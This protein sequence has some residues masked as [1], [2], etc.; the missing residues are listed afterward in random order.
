[1][2]TT[3]IEAS[4]IA[5]GAVPSTGFTSVQIFTAASTWTK[6]TDI[7]KVVVEVQGAGGAG[8]RHTTAGNCGGGTAG[9]YVMA[10][11]DVTDIDKATV[12]IGSGGVGTNTNGAGADGG[13]S[14]FAKHTGSGTFVTLSA[15][16]GNGGDGVYETGTQ[17]VGGTGPSGAL[18]ISSGNT[19]G[20]LGTE[21]FGGESKF[22]FAGTA[23]YN[24]YTQYPNASGYGAGGGGAYTITAG[25]GTGGLVIVWEYK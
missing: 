8:A 9:G 21:W 1:L 16:G 23:A 19:G 13:L 12:V 20:G 4:N 10:V 5:T 25:S 3:K 17:G 6:P 7:T 22:G 18:I 11:L 14:S 24:S 15:T 2:A